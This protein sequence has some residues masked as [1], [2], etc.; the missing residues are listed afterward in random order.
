MSPTYDYFCSACNLKVEIFE[1]IKAK[2]RKKCPKCGKPKLRRV[3]SKDTGANIIFKGDGFYRS[4]DYI[5]QKS[6][7]N[8]ILHTKRKK[9]QES[10]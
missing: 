5:N 4:T 8:G 3:I 2:P 10:L 6:R 9:K 7:E 1:S